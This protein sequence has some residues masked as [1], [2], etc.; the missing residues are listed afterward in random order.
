MTLT[1]DIAQAM[2]L[3]S[4]QGVL[5][6]S[7][8]PGSPADQAGLKGSTQSAN[9]NGQQMMIG[10]DVITAADGQTVTSIEQLVA[11]VQA[12]NAGDTMNLTII[13]NGQQQNLTAAPQTQTTPGTGSSGATTSAGGPWLGVSGVA[14]PSQLAQVLG[15]GNQGG[16]L[17]VSVVPGSPA[18]K[19]GLKGAGVNLGQSN[20]VNA[21]V[22]VAVNGQNV[23]TME[24]LA[25]AIQSKNV[26]DAVTLTIVRNG[27]RQDVQVTLGARPNQ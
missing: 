16:V 14:V 13:R 20:A 2:N 22:V 23:T 24:E 25:S 10:G 26:G 6:V 1:P 12:K 9:V 17:L 3:G 11:A 18:E 21:D 7:V 5:V 19:A 8:V 4:R 27:Q 15:L